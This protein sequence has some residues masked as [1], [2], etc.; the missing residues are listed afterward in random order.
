MPKR[1]LKNYTMLEYLNLEHLG[2]SEILRHN[3]TNL[4]IMRRVLV[5]YRQAQAFQVQAMRN[6]EEGLVSPFYRKPKLGCT[7]WSKYF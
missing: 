5:E 3:Q 2:C 4:L 6:Q 7:N 1:D